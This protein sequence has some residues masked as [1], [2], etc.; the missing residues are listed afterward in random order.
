MVDV[1]D[2]L[3]PAQGLVPSGG[4]HSLPIS[5]G[6]AFRAGVILEIKKRQPY[7]VLISDTYRPLSKTMREQFSK[8]E[9]VAQF[10][11]THPLASFGEARKPHQL[12]LYR[13]P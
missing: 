8:Y 7:F 1:P 4:L 10:E 13:R 6:G 11:Y 9:Q 5:Y 12:Y 2:H 3:W